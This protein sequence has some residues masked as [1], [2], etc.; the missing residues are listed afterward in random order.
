MKFK[1]LLDEGK[2][3]G[4]EKINFNLRL[5]EKDLEFAKK[6]IETENYNRAM[7]TAYEAVLRAGNKLMNFLGY[8]VIGKEHHKNVF[9]FLREIDI[10]QELTDYFDMVRIKRNN[11]IYRDVETI[12]EKEAEEIIKKAE[13]FVHKI[14]T[15]VH[16]IGTE[17][18][19]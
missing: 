15:F 8:R 2:I 18:N 7:A 5:A 1:K 19:D 3:E 12:S 10:D 14:G 11:F 17:E 9:A 4:V 6:G 13:E 16:K